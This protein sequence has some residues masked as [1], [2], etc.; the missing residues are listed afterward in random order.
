MQK[1]RA[2]YSKNISTYP[3]R[4]KIKDADKYLNQL[5]S[6]GQFADLIPYE[7]KIYDNGWIEAGNYTEDRIWGFIWRM[8]WNA[9]GR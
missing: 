2:Y 3:I 5:N 6:E 9:C 8:R 4:S 7:E 1:L